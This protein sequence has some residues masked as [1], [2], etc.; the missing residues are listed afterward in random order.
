MEYTSNILIESFS[1]LLFV[2]SKSKRN[3]FFK[4]AQGDYIDSISTTFSSI[5][6]DELVRTVKKLASRDKIYS[7]Y[8][9]LCKKI[10]LNLNGDKKFEECYTRLVHFSSSK[11]LLEFNES[12]QK[13]F[14]YTQNI[15]LP[16]FSFLKNEKIINFFLKTTSMD[17]RNL[18]I[19]NPRI[20]SFENIYIN[21]R[22]NKIFFVLGS[23]LS[24]DAL[25][26]SFPCNE[27]MY[28]S[29]YIL[30][31]IVQKILKENINTYA[32]IKKNNFIKNE[33]SYSFF[34][35]NNKTDFKI[36]ILAN[37]IVLK[38]LET[39]GLK[40]HPIEKCLS[41]RGLNNLSGIKKLININQ[42]LE[43][44]VADFMQST[45]G[46][47][48]HSYDINSKTLV[49][50]TK[51]MAN[52]SIKI[53]LN[54]NA[55][56]VAL[57]NIFNNY[58]YIMFG[59][60]HNFIEYYTFLS[61]LIPVLY[62]YGFKY[63]YLEEDE[64]KQKLFDEYIDGK[65][66]SA[67]FL[68][69]DSQ[70][71]LLKAIKDFNVGKSSKLRVLLYDIHKTP[72]APGSFEVFFQQREKLLEE[73]IL[74]LLQQTNEKGIILC[75]ATHACVRH[76]NKFS[77]NYLNHTF[78]QGIKSFCQENGKKVFSFFSDAINIENSYFNY[79]HSYPLRRTVAIN[80]IINYKYSLK[81]HIMKKSKNNICFLKSIDTPL[82]IINYLPNFYSD[83]DIC[84]YTSESLIITP[85]DL[86]FDG[87]FY[88][89]FFTEI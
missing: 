71:V 39:A 18:C 56:P 86:G 35:K 49:K 17:L 9:F 8:D 26:Y 82:D 51:K 88:F 64:G 36:F 4:N 48:F 3:S 76:V 54:K 78:A 21:E 84:K 63:I 13:G 6:E 1:I 74:A 83:N 52:G 45:G 5:E 43:K 25:A 53:N 27:E 31:E 69:F 67:D 59:E 41:Q 16:S 60:L 57:K 32:I 80:D 34:W 44:T 47:R 79:N 11:I 81:Y 28:V 2:F 24:E 70:K 68:F 15:A 61:N 66:D 50:N 12:W 72:C 20:S 89:P 87:Y 38:I 40:T 7:F 42:N 85:F 10:F 58:D 29:Y 55:L 19:I 30:S 62:S 46:I 77:K 14:D 75:G 33:A 22:N 73:K 23:Y 37:A 65:N